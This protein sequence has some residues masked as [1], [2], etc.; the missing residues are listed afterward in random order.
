MR[1]V[2]VGDARAASFCGDGMDPD[3]L[4]THATQSGTVEGCPGHGSITSA[5]V[6]EVPCDVL[7]PASVERVIDETTSKAS[8]AWLIVEAAN[9]PITPNADEVLAERGIRVVPDILANAGGVVV[10]HLEWVQHREGY[11]W[12]GGRG[13]R[14]AQAGRCC[15]RSRRCGRA[16]TDGTSPRGV[17]ARDRARREG[18]ART[19]P[20]SLILV[21]RPRLCRRCVPG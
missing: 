7:I 1:V 12:T 6:L 16:R 3:R 10:S 4:A 15:A 14:A 18:T 20:L 2:A 9:G 17:V 5:E 11:T 21:R 8:N 13:E 19:R